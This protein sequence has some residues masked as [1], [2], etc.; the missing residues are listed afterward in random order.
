MD[1]LP[2]FGYLP[3]AILFLLVVFTMVYLRQVET[4][5]IEKKFDRKEII[6]T[7]FG[8]NFFGRESEPGGPLRSSGALVLLRSGMYYRARFSSRE[9]F[10]PG[11]DI[12][13]LGVTDAFKGRPLHQQVM[14]IGFRAGEGKTD[15]AAFRLPHIAQW[16]AAIKAN[17]LGRKPGGPG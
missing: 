17:L 16:A 3:F 5:R 15:R 6:I 4:R 8:V 2:N 10:I 14:V 1:G 9:L 7:S 11:P 12:T 13:Y